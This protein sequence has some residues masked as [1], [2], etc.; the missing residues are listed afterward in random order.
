MK[1]SCAISTFGWYPRPKPTSKEWKRVGSI[2]TW[3]YKCSPKPTSKEWKRDKFAVKIPARYRV[4]SLPRRNENRDTGNTPARTGFVR[5]LPRRNENNPYLTRNAEA[6]GPKPTSKEWKL[7]FHD[8]LH[9]RHVCPKP[10]SKEWKL[11]T[12]YSVHVIPPVR[13]LPRRNEN[14]NKSCRNCLW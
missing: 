11:R 5:S 4:R 6:T 14:N 7:I 1:T 8:L 3:S 2:R 13:S 10:T 9:W 12:H